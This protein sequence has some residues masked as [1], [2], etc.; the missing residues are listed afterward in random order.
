M[1]GLLP[2]RWCLG[3]SNASR[4]VAP[5]WSQTNSVDDITL[6]QVYVNDEQAVKL[7]ATESVYTAYG[8]TNDTQYLFQVGGD[9]VSGS[10][11]T[12]DLISDTIVGQTGPISAPQVTSAPVL[13]NVTGG[14]VVVQVTPSGDSGG[15]N[16]TNLTAIAR[17][18]DGTIASTQ[19]KSLNDTEFTFNRLDAQTTYRISAFATNGA[20]LS[21]SE[22]TNL[23]VTTRSIDAPGLCPPPTVVNVTGTSEA[24]EP[25]L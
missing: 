6:F 4:K 19:V 9:L 17:R 15:C 24:P 25:V 16:L 10:N 14:V 12:S 3:T 1:K 18:S 8:L 23:T 22:S 5:A 13:T 7:G 20:G 21:S 11:A 2:A